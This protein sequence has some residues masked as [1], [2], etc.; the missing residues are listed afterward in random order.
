MI[1]FLISI[2][3]IISRGD[4]MENI[5]IR[6]SIRTYKEETI[7]SEHRESLAQY[8]ETLEK[9][10]DG[11]FRFP[12]IDSDKDLDGKVGTYGVIQGAKLYVCGLVNKDT[13]D[14][15]QLGYAFEKI[16]LFATSLGLGTCWLGGTFNRSNLANLAGIEPDEML[17]IASPIGYIEEKKSIIDSTMRKLAK[18]DNRKP[19]DELFFHRSNSEP[20]GKVSLGEFGDVLEMV[21]IA[22]S[23]SNKQPWRIIKDKDI[24]HLFLERTPKYAASLSFDIQMIDMGIALCHFETALDELEIKGSFKKE[25]QDIPEWKDNEYITS[26]IPD[27]I[28]T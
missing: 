7:S 21:R 6:K 13:M 20:L 28:I 12:L 17:I 27:I 3:D 22:P 24:Y 4:F 19:W 11:K 5:K 15:V 18:S 14:L 8:I 26:W 16:V 9:S 25:D 23:A 10:Y 2:H 1:D